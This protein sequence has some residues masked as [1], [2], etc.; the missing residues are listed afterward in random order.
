MLQELVA[1][2]RDNNI[3]VRFGIHPV[4][5][6]SLSFSSSLLPSGGRGGGL[7]L[8]LAS[9]SVCLPAP[10]ASLV[11]G[12][13]RA[14]WRKALWLTRAREARR[15]PGQLNVLLAEAGVPYDVVLEMDEINDDFANSDVAL[16]IGA[17]PPPPLPG[18][19]R[20]LRLCLWVSEAGAEA[21]PGCA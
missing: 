14:R 19:S 21:R 11:Q 3:N 20:S 15:M 16:C 6:Y 17:P 12:G 9:R 8:V 1:T 13:G 10:G 5:G 7:V 2:L 18:P 4:A